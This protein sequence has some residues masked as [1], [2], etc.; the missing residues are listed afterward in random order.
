MPAEP[1][2][3]RGGTVG[4]G[5]PD[6]PRGGTAGPGEPDAPRG[7]TAGPGEPDPPPRQDGSAAPRP[8]RRGP[9]RATG[10]TFTGAEPRLPGLEVPPRGAPGT[11]G[12][13]A[14]A[15]GERAHEEWLRA[16]RP[17]HWG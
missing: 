16:Q 11:D 6:A 7:G 1:D 15:A 3:P 8:R 5:E 9:R 12:E 2:P 4:P 14:G 17:P 10:G 13:P